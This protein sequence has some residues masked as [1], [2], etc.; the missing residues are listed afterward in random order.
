MVES[1]VGLGLRN[2]AITIDRIISTKTHF[3]HHGKYYKRVESMFSAIPWRS[4]CV[5]R[6]VR[7]VL[8]QVG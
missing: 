2:I 5:S 7:R 6:I 4:I 3:I 1:A 8:H